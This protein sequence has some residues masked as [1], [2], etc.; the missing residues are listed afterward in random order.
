MARLGLAIAAFGAITVTDSPSC[1]DALAGLISR[2]LEDQPDVPL[3]LAQ[4][5]A[6]ALRLTRCNAAGIKST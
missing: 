3:R 6:L 4:D 1:R 5:R 2:P